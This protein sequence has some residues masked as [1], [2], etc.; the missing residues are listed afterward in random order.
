MAPIK[1]SKEY[2]KILELAAKGSEVRVDASV[3]HD[4]RIGEVNRSA[5]RVSRARC[6]AEQQPSLSATCKLATV[7]LSVFDQL[8]IT[9]EAL[10]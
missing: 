4:A 5:P 3:T 1:G 2:L 10:Q 6:S 7:D 8:L 9:R